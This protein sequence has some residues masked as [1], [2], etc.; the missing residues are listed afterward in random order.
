MTLNW[1]VSPGLFDKDKDSNTH[2]TK[3]GV[4]D[5][6]SKRVAMCPCQSIYSFYFLNNI[7]LKIKVGQLCQLLKLKL[8]KILV[9]GYSCPMIFI[10]HLN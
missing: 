8:L 10:K 7:T 6:T 2:T 4:G 3:V 5:V 1:P 9:R